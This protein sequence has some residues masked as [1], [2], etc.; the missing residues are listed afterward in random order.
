MRIL[1]VAAIAREVTEFDSGENEKL[2][3]T[4]A[5]NRG[6]IEA[7]LSRVF[8]DGEGPVFLSAPFVLNAFRIWHREIS[9]R[10]IFAP[11]RVK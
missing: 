2:P 9:S 1:R 11:G 4:N 3:A 8:R 7:S 10:Y 6:V 5:A